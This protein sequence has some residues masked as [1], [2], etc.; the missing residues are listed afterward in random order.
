MRRREPYVSFALPK[1]SFDVYSFVCIL[2]FGGSVLQRVS[3]QSDAPEFGM[4]WADWSEEGE[5]ARKHF[6]EL[7]LDSIL[8]KGWSRRRYPW[9]KVE[10]CYDQKGGSSSIIVTYG[11]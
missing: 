11:A 2:W 7:L 9:G 10:S 5:F 3:V 8:G 6:H 4:S 1:A